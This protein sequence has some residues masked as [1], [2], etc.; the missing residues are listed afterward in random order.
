MLMLWLISDY[1]G[2]F[3]YLVMEVGLSII[4]DNNKDVRHGINWEE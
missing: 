4:I 1:F 2:Y 3:I